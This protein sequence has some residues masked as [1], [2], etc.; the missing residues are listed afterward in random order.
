MTRKI[1][2]AS[3]VVLTVLAPGFLYGIGTLPVHAAPA[4]P[5]PMAAQKPAKAAPAVAFTDA[6]GVRHPLASYKGHYVLLNMWATWCAP[7]VAELPALTRLKA[8]VPGLTVL[9]VNMDRGQVDAAGFL[10]SHNASSL[11]SLRDTDIALMK[12][13]GAFGLPTTVLIDPKGNVVAPKARP[14]GSGDCLL[15]ESQLKTGRRVGFCGERCAR[16][17]REHARRTRSAKTSA[18]IVWERGA[19]RDSRKIR[20][21]SFC[22]ANRLRHISP[23]AG[24]GG[25]L[26]PPGLHTAPASPPGRY[27]GR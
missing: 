14:L 25:I 18:L 5:K 26:N 7:C 24:R 11:G 1:R 10:K 19:R 2:K 13:F 23:S 22:P 8:A 9:A 21:R 20:G 15:Q 4:M 12:N 3:L 16:L 6:A 27:P 17:A